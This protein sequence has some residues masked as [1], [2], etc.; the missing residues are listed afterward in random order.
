MFIARESGVKHLKGRS[1]PDRGVRWPIFE[2]DCSIE[3]VGPEPVG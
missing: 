3:G 1:M 2:I